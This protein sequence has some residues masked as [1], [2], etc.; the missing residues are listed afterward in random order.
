MFWVV[1]RGLYSCFSTKKKKKNV[2]LTIT[3]KI[4]NYTLDK[5]QFVFLIEKLKDSEAPRF[6]D[7]I[8]LILMEEKKKTVF[9]ILQLKLYNN[10][11]YG[12]FSGT[13]K[14][15]KEEC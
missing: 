13:S 4:I 15:S 11:L 2:V 3:P 5:C 10:I 12:A 1:G 14:R 7:L 9:T 6:I 8:I